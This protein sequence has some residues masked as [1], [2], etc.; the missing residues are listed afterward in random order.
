MKL[1]AGELR[2]K[3]FVLQQDG[4]MIPDY[5]KVVKKLWEMEKETGGAQKSID[6]WCRMLSEL[7]VCRNALG[8]DEL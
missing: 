2:F 5:D 8:M 7:E 6:E 3:I 1:T 4:L